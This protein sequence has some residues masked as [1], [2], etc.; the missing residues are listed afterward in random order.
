VSRVLRAPR[1]RT[2]AIQLAAGGLCG[3]VAVSVLIASGVVAVPQEAPSEAASLPILGCFG[4]GSVL[5]MA[6]PNARMLVTARSGDANWYQVFLPTPIHKHGWVNA[7]SVQLLGDGSQL[8]IAGCEPAPTSIAAAASPTPAASSAPASAA[9]SLALIDACQVVTRAD[10]E[11]LARTP[12]NAGQPG[13]PVEPSCM[14]AGPVTGPV[15]QVQVFIGDGAKKT[16]D[17]DRALHHRF[18]RVAG[19]A[20]EALEEANAIFLRKGTIWVALELVRL[21]DPAT[22]RLPLERLARVIATRLP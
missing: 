20:D 14:Y 12:L 5:A 1:W 13:N 3:I 22:N 19:I 7:A 2:S 11:A 4:S 17:I 6:R 9:A 18:T 8:P 10:A 21:N 15:A 16:L